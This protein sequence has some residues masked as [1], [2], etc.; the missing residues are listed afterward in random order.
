M[1]VFRFYLNLFKEN[2]YWIKKTAFLGG[3]SLIA[4]V[5]VFSLQ[6][7]SAPRFMQFLR[8]I[9]AD[10][11]EG[12]EIAIDMATAMA[13]FKNNVQAGIIGL[14]GGIALGIIPVLSVI[15]NFFIIGYLFAFFSQQRAEGLL[16]FFVSVV[17]HA[18]VEIPLFLITAAFGLR[19]GWFWK[20]N[21]ELSNW[22]KLK[23]CLKDN[24]KLVPLLVVGFFLAALAE[25]FV[26]GRLAERYASGQF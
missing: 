2:K 26:S 7:E 19:L 25:I 11:L 13:I 24:L 14:F 17:P 10:I 3:F 4:G 16:V 15:V 9:F 8:R 1:P 20:I 5:L 22:E 6:P 12:K 23:L 18:I 21:R